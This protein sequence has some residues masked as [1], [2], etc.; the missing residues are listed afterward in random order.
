MIKRLIVGILLLFTSF[1]LADEKLQSNKSFKIFIL[2]SYHPSFEWTH[3]LN[4]GILKLL[5]KYLPNARIVTEYADS[6]RIN[7]E[8]AFKTF[9]MI[10]KRKYPNFNFDL[11]IITDN[12]GLDFA[13]EN[14]ALFKN[15]PIVASGISNY[16][17][18]MLQ[19]YKSVTLIEEKIHVEETLKQALKLFPA[20]KKIWAVYGNAVIDNVHSKLFFNA[21][22]KLKLKLPYEVI[23]KYSFLGAQKKIAAIPKSDI[24][25]YFTFNL[26]K[27]GNFYPLKIAQKILFKKVKA[28]VFTF[29][30]YHLGYKVVGGS[31]QSGLA[32]GK[33]TAVEAVK[34]LQYPNEIN[35]FLTSPIHNVYDYKEVCKF[36][37]CENRFPENIILINKPKSFYKQNV[38][39]YWLFIALL[40]F[41]LLALL[42]YILIKKQSDKAIK[43][44]RAKYKLL[45]E[46]AN[47]AMFF[48][49]LTEENEISD[50]I[51]V[52]SKACSLFGYSK[53]E[54]KKLAPYTIAQEDQKDIIKEQLAIILE[55][56]QVLFEINYISKS[57]KAITGEINAHMFLEGGRYL[58][59]AIFRDITERKKAQKEIEES[60]K[61]FESLFNNISD[62]TFLISY[63]DDSYK[64]SGDFLEVNQI[65]CNKLGFSREEFL[66]KSI[67]DIELEPDK[68]SQIPV[69]EVK[70]RLQEEKNVIFL[71][72]FKGKNGHLME[73]EVSANLFTH[74]NRTLVL[75]VCRDLTPRAQMQELLIQQEKMISVGQMSSGIAHELNNPLGV[76]LQA[77]QNL[78]RRLT[79]PTQNN[80]EKMQEYNINFANLEKY[81]EERKINSYI[82]GI[83]DAGKRASEIVANLLSFVRKSDSKKESCSFKDIINE[84][85][86][87]ASQSYNSKL[88]VDFKLINLVLDIEEDLP[89]IFC[90]KTELEQVILNLLINAAQ[91][92]S[93]KLN[94]EPKIEIS[95]KYEDENFLLKICDNGPGMD[96]EQ[97]RRAFEPFYTTKKRDGTGLGLAIVYFIVKEHH[98][99]NIHLE[100][101]L[102]KGCCFTIAIPDCTKK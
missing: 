22:K 41:I 46:K 20:T 98:K 45:F 8:K 4:H 76:I 70:N 3:N 67:F 83:F 48:N 79:D 19:K 53:E 9:R 52:N 49:L 97:R 55:K 86:V 62:I 7:K 68:H 17:P 43:K 1:C 90:N 59:L 10:L 14:R 64:S 89:I 77:I 96:S 36:N 102:G 2:H 60:Q 87:L 78:K 80:I 72:T 61:L 16:T 91:A 24:I 88:G 25:I 6:K 95:L 92:M 21:Y 93:K 5:K 39:L 51:D 73:V 56:K 99:G 30:R 23:Q 84:S 94:N 101:K 31:I 69:I 82:N 34:R 65:A 33:L 32:D 66:E 85:I 74:N 100:S 35:K 54:F 28:P 44:S 27:K 11:M 12:N 40:L 71:R 26:D 50:F 81:F 42:I 13:L 75:A 47:D 18:K 29:W 57:G 58:F 37:L 38:D 63:S 15:I